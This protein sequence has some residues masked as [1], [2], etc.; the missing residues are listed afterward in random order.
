MSDKLGPRA[1]EPV[2]EPM[3]GVPMP[4]LFSEPLGGPSVHH[5]FSGAALERVRFNEPRYYPPPPRRIWLPVALF[6][7]TILSTFWAG[8]TGS[9]PDGPLEIYKLVTDPVE[10]LFAAMYGFRDG[11]IYMTAVMSILLAHEMGHFVQAVR[12][13]VP[14]SLPYFIPM[15]LTPLGTMGAVIA[16]RGSQA[17]RRE[18]FDIGISGPIAGLVLAVPIAC[19]GIAWATPEGSPMYL[20]DP[21]VFRWLIHWFHPEL[22]SDQ[23]LAWNPLYMAGWVGMLITGLNMMPISQLDGGHVSYALLGRWAHWLARALVLCGVIFILAAD[24]YGWIV[25]LALVTYLG[26]DHPRT[27]D[28]RAPLGWWRIAL[29]WIS[30]AIPVLC[31][32]PVPIR[33]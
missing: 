24:Q 20:G 25:M 31:F 27:A 9:T 4:G 32:V 30:L 14:V 17:N 11:L 15:A 21:L 5:A 22:A 23:S 8:A 33:T 28:D 2:S 10:V 29:G 18:L 26:T 19:L 7:T 12:Y 3:R 1:S 16:M 6:V 13:R